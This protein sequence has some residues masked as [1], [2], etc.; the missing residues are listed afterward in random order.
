M[1]SCQ[2][3]MQGGIPFGLYQ[4]VHIRGDDV[5]GEAGS[6]HPLNAIDGA[7]QRDGVKSHS[8][9]DDGIRR[10][11]RGNWWLEDGWHSLGTAAV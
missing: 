5:V 10:L 7:F 11:R 9:D 3:L 2:Y 8:Q 4:E 6:D 1:G